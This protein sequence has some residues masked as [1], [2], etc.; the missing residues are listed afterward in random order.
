[1]KEVN[2]GFSLQTIDKDS[3]LAKKGYK[4]L[5]VRSASNIKYFR[6]LPNYG[7]VLQVEISD[8]PKRNIIYTL[9]NRDFIEISL[10]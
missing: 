4:K 6:R 7:M 5:N 2:M 3:L 8:Q 10:A 1:M 9:R